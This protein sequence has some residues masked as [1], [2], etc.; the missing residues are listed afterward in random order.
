MPRSLYRLPPAR[1]LAIFED[2]GRTLNFTA[3]AR[4]LGLSQA[5]VSK[6]IQQLEGFLDLRLFTRNRRGLTLT[7][8][9]RR[10]HEAVASGLQH[11]AR[12]MEDLRPRFEAGRV[13]IT[14]TIALASVWLMPRIAQFRAEYS[15][16]DIRL[17]ATDEVLDLA[18]EGIDLG[19]RYGQGRWPGV[20]T[21]HLFGV[22][23]FPVASPA[24]LARLGPLR[25]ADDLSAATLL[26]MDEPNSR[27]AD[28]DVWFAAI[29]APVSPASRALRFNNYPLLVQA[30][31][32]GQGIALGWGHVVQDYL[33]SG[34]L[35]QC[36][37]T[38]RLLE[39]AFHLVTPLE[40]PS[41]PEA[42]VFA[43]WL[44]A[45]TQ[46]LREAA[47]APAGVAPAGAAPDA[48]AP[49]RAETHGGPA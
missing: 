16:I 20:T 35:V 43:E 7:A 41:R 15:G 11:I 40:L 26:H 23:L 46:A 30:A 27:D 4:N 29:G 12:T 22:L 5:A 1:T 6:Q 3:T 24:Y 34:A 44:L 13:T 47:G 9:G 32:S 28:W 8:S 18:A 45:Q 39:P 21:R 37:P 31:L 49:G 38:T 14:T 2:A 10:L 33:A 42:A 48:A 36:L 25:S 17:I 19:L